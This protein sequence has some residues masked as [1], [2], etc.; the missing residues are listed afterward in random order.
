[1]EQKQVKK[2][3]PG[4]KKGLIRVLIKKGQLE[5]SVQLRIDLFVDEPE[6]KKVKT[7]IT[8]Q[9]QELKGVSFKKG[10]HVEADQLSFNLFEDEPESN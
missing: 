8:V 9:N 7:P 1:M 6:S 4:Q 2:P 5:E 3:F 10:Q